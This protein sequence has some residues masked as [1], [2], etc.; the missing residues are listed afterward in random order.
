MDWRSF[1]PV[2]D[3]AVICN[4][5]M[6]PR[7]STKNSS[8]AKASSLR[9]TAAS[10]NSS[11]TTRAHCC[12]GCAAEIPEPE[13]L[14]CSACGVW[15]N[16]YCAGIP[17]SHFATISTSFICAACSLTASKSI[18]L[19]LRGEIDA[20]KAE[21]IELRATMEDMKSKSKQQ[22]SNPSAEKQTSSSNGS[23][24]RVVKRSGRR[25][26][27]RQARKSN[28]SATHQHPNHGDSAVAH[29]PPSVPVAPADKEIV[30]SVRR[31]WGTKKDVSISTIVK[32]LKQHTSVGNKVA[33]QRKIRRIANNRMHWWYLVR[34][35]ESVLEELDK[36][37]EQVTSATDS[38]RWKLEQC[39]RPK[40]PVT[41]DSEN[42]L[43]QAPSEAHTA[44]A[45]VSTCT[46]QSPLNHTT[47]T[48]TDTSAQA[49][50]D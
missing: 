5:K 48:D 22:A 24:A 27:E 29:Q 18:I 8:K 35:D 32:T 46:M 38:A 31:I 15:L 25:N 39:R 42:F 47:T 21:I 50:Q 30:P 41:V 28:E 10:V 34:S 49:H 44:T 4:S 6:P 17:T 37:W 11:Q 16:R 43:K 12:D 20:L 2:V 13:A 1:P 36:E 33:I 3:R 26:A 19:E 40:K 9:K 23:W 7:K 45:E 14:N